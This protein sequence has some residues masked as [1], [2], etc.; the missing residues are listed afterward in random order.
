MKPPSFEYHVPG[1]VDE[2]VGLL[3]ELGEDAKAIAGGQSLV[4]MLALR[5]A[6]PEHLVDLRRL[7][8]LR[9]VEERGATVRIGA[10]TT[11]AAVARSAEV[12]RSVPLMARATPLIGH[13]QIRNRGTVGGSL[14]HADA[15]AEYPA[16]VLAL[17]AEL[18]AVSPR[19]TRTIP[20][21][22]FFTGLWSTALDEDELLTAIDLP[23]R[24]GRSGFA[25]EEFARRGGDFAIAGAAVAVEV[26]DAGRVARCGIG[27]FG[28]GSTP[29]RA[30]AAETAA[31]GA[32]LADIDP[33]EL[34]RTAIGELD[35]VPADLHASADHRAHVGAVIV[36]RAW[37]R[38]AEEAGRRAA[39][40]AA[41]G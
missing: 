41:N 25:I 16:V 22:D 13:F 14:A 38:A 37:R 30:P 20:A 2:A 29:L 8:G 24:R 36:A 18:Q 34:G 17:D 33:D 3:A 4:P 26:D 19:G 7:D 12:A 35:A 39:E 28:L 15:A 32:A 23:V 5:L 31:T 27:L 40:E 11:Q 9:G 1:D 10:G 6:N 21:G